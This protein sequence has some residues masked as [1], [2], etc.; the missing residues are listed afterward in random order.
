M[1]GGMDYIL[2]ATGRLA[3]RGR[4]VFRS[5]GS[6]AGLGLVTLLVGCVAMKPSSVHD[7]QMVDRTLTVIVSSGYTADG[8]PGR[9]ITVR[10]RSRTGR[11]LA[12][13]ETSRHGEITLRIRYSAVDP[14]QQIE[15]ISDDR[16]SPY[17]IGAYGGAVV[18]VRENVS[19]YCIVLPA[20][21]VF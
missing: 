2:A 13:G 4:D 18:S 8:Q 17:P 10:V 16:L 20:E 14:A 7:T 5:I 21:C 15:A 11:L 6:F 1:V 9:A 3:I 12:S 19:K